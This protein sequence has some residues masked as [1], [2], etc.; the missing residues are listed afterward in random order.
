M[1][2]TIIYSFYL[3][4]CYSEFCHYLQKAKNSISFLYFGLVQMFGS[5]SNG[6]LNFIEQENIAQS[7]CFLGRPLS[8]N[9]LVGNDV[10]CFENIVHDSRQTNSNVF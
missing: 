4:N 10:T 5:D 3:I 7:S 8:R 1:Y 6:Y 9:V 2:V